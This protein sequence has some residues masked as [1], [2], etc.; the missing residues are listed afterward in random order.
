VNFYKKGSEVPFFLVIGLI[1]CAAGLIVLIFG[2][3]IAAGM[4]MLE[5]R[6]N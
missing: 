5:K 3:K 4:G 6:N 1:T 2:K